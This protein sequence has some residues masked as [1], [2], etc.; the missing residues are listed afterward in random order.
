M[1]CVLSLLYTAAGVPKSVNVGES[2]IADYVA[3]D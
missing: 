1:C 3:D 2:K